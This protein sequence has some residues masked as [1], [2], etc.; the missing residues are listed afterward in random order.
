M[1]EEVAQWWAEGFGDSYHERNRVNWQERMP[2]WQSALEF[3]TPATVLEVGCG[4]GWNLRAIMARQ[5]SIECHGIDINAG[6]VEE[7]RQ[8]GIEARCGTAVSIAGHYD[9]GSM[10]LVFTSGVLIH[11]PPEQLE[12][13]MRA[14]ITTSARYVLAIEYDAE[15]AEEIDYRGHAGKLWK[16]P[17][18]QLYQALGL[19]LLSQGVAGG[20]DRSTYYL[21]EKA[22]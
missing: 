20:F 1:V 5:P 2:F 14:I 7:A 22:A 18:G 10:D 17:Y 3:C 12:T 8:A 6:A 19:K 16:R 13:V 21:L 11:I 15:E 9:A 4:P